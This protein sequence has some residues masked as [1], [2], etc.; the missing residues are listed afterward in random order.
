MQCSVILINWQISITVLNNLTGSHMKKRCNIYVALIFAFLFFLSSCGGSQAIIDASKSLLLHSL[1]QSTVSDDGVPGIVLGIKTADTDWIAAAG[2]ADLA[3]GEL[4]TPEDQVRLASVTKST[5]AML[6][7]KLVEE[8]MIA[9]TDTVEKY[10]PGK[11]AR[12]SEITVHMLL[13]HTSGVYDH[14]NSQE[15]ADRLKTDP[16]SDW[17][18]DEVL[19]VSNAHGLDFTPGSQYKY[20]NTGYYILGMIAEAVTGKTVEEEISHRIFSPLGLTRTVLSRRGMMTSPYAHGYTWISDATGLI[21]NSNWNLSW[22]WTAGAGVSTAPDMLILMRGLMSGL[23]VSPSTL[24]KMTRPV[25]PATSYGYGLR[26]GYEQSVGEYTIGH[27]GANQGTITFWFYFPNR[28]W[29][30]FTAF[31]RLDLQDESGTMHFDSFTLLKQFVTQVLEI[32]K[33]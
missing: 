21:D 24:E 33:S 17:T 5:T 14:E 8:G 4:M 10:L 7:M 1:L 28:N 32:L 12:G 30:I 2:K 23:I 27:T 15:W 11:V 6:I 22:D 19:A 25:A 18:E 20:S 13:N 26:V 16:T 31:N 3:A 29:I 9:L